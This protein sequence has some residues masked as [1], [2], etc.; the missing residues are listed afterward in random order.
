MAKH[1]ERGSAS[2]LV[3]VLVVLVV[4]VGFNYQRNLK[5]EAREFRPYRTYAEADLDALIE[6]SEQAAKSAGRRYDSRV[7][8]RSDAHE[9]G[10]FMGNV[11][12]FERVQ[13]AGRRTREA[14][15]SF[16]GARV[17]LEELKQ[18]RSR[19]AGERSKLRVFLRRAFSF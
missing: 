12:E 14:R 1:P 17:S 15:D 10:H 13:A 5:A 18:E 8:R 16:A 19:R 2:P 3:L 11:E 6:A 9:T 4:G 7:E